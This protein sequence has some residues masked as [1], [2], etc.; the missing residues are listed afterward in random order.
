MKRAEKKQDLTARIV[1]ATREL[2]AEQGVHSLKARDIS[3]RAGCAL[4]GLY[5]V[6]KDI[7][8]V[9]M[10]INLES[11]QYLNSKLDEAVATAELPEDKLPLIVWAYLDFARSHP[12]FWRAMF[13]NHIG[14]DKH[15]PLRHFVELERLMQ[16]FIG[17]LKYLNPKEKPE[18]LKRRARTFFAA[19]HGVITMGL[20]H[21]FTGNSGDELDEELIALMTMV[22]STRSS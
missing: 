15:Y 10:T 2:I 1:N 20:D 22:L 11:F 3:E 8:D 16:H 4:G 17:P 19:F 5:T 18:V 21:Q 9:V 7:D 13:E 12:K 6:F 14:N